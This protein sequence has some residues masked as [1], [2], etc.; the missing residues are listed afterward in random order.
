M[1]NGTCTI[2]THRAYHGDDTLVIRGKYTAYHAEIPAPDP[3]P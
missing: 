3:A 1:M 2:R